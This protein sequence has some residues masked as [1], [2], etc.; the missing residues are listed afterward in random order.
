MFSF[1]RVLLTFFRNIAHLLNWLFRC[2]LGLV[3]ALNAPVVGQFFD[4]VSLFPAE[5]VSIFAFLVFVAIFK[6]V[7]G[8]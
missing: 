4:T 7:R 2:I 3:G 6:F 1:F 8:H 5:L